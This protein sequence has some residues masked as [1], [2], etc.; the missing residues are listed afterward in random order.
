MI[1]KITEVELEKPNR[2]PI[3]IFHCSNCQK[4][5]PFAEAHY[6]TGHGKTIK[7]LIDEGI[8]A[9]SLYCKECVQKI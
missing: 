1:R 2:E 9:L 8:F 7:N 3:L 6:L 5:F 4:E